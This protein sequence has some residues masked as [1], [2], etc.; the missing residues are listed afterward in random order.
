MGRYL[1]AEGRTS[2][3]SVFSSQLVQQLVAMFVALRFAARTA[4]CGD[5][6]LAVV[7]L[8]DVTSVASPPPAASPFSIL[9]SGLGL[10]SSTV[11]SHIAQQCVPLVVHTQH[12]VAGTDHATVVKP[13][14]PPFATNVM[15]P[16]PLTLG[17][18]S[19]L[20]FASGADSSLPLSLRSLHRS[21]SGAMSALRIGPTSTVGVSPYSSVSALIG[22]FGATRS[23]GQAPEV[24]EERVGVID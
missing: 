5:P 3:T 15:P 20:F 12:P 24:R 21:A 18:Y 22:S 17:R 23:T 13:P 7:D 11:A 6:R 14:P 2:L 16:L 19:S 8:C 1:G 4:G 9:H 10:T